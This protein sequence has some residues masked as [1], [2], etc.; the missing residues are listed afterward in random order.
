MIGR[1]VPCSAE[2]S[3][4]TGRFG[5]LGI[6]KK[7]FGIL[8]QAERKRAVGIMI[9]MIIGAGLETLGVSLMVP[10]ATAVLDKEQNPEIITVMLIALIAVFI[11][12]N[13]FLFFRNWAQYRYTTDIHR[14]IQLDTVH[15]YMTRPYSYFLNM[16]SGAI[17]RTV[18]SD[19]FQVYYLMNSLLVVYSELFVMV[20]MI[21]VVMVI[22]PLMTLFVGSCLAIEYVLIMGKI[23]P[24]LNK[25]G[26]TARK[27]GGSANRWLVQMI[28]GIKSIRVTN[29]E[30][31]FEEN[32]QKH[33][34]KMTRM[35]RGNVTFT[36]LPRAI[37]ESVTISLMLGVLLI[38]HLRHYDLTALVPMLSAMVVA[39]VRLLP[40]VN[41]F[42]NATSVAAYRKSALEVITKIYD[43]MRGQSETTWQSEDQ[44]SPAAAEEGFAP[45][46]ERPTAAFVEPISF[47]NEIRME[48]VSFTYPG[49]EEPVLE[50][51][52]LTIRKGQTIGLIGVSGAGKT[53]AADI[54]LGLLSPNEGRVT[55]DGWDIA[56]DWRRW[57]ASIAYIPQEIFIMSGTIREN[58]AFGVPAEERDE[59]KIW[60]AL[61]DARLADHVRTLPDGLDTDIGEAGIRL[62]GGQRQRIGIARALYR[63][64]QI[65]FFDEATSSLDVQTESELMESI[66]AL[67]DKKTMVIITHRLSTL[68]HS[69]VIYQVN[70]GRV[71]AVERGKEL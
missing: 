58:V 49:A 46:E 60:R 31:F 66:N 61:E 44:G 5:M 25:L 14:R 45:A 54:L 40:A 27:E 59:E 39:A 30:Q 51:A 16:N 21:A 55:V 2:V 18:N 32:Y 35:E 10:L 63:D 28:R 38:L 9:L 12:K 52:N 43:E 11:L 50:N 19:T 37:I 36:S 4:E 22:S 48:N 29:T 42:S 33:I 17:I 6:T 26:E 1:F 13:A 7:L 62:S 15:Y 65:L 69:D 3:R 53:T 70:E 41:R 56:E 67:K 64:P 23:K 68:S 57:V 71:E 47:E 24:R 34:V 20:I 8:T